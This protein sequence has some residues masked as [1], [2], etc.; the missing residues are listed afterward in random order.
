MQKSVSFMQFL[1]TLLLFSGWVMI[2][3]SLLLF[4]IAQMP[5]AGIPDRNHCR[6]HLD[7][8]KRKIPGI[9]EFRQNKNIRHKALQENLSSRANEQLYT[10]LVWII[11]FLTL[12]R[13]F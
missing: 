5:V 4:N 11:T 13:R 9:K 6:L 10:V 2:M 7:N 12:S 8:A 3:G 1:L